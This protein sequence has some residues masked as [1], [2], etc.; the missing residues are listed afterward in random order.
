MIFPYLNKDALREIKQVIIIHGG[1]ELIILLPECPWRSYK[2]IWRTG[3]RPSD[4]R[5]HPPSLEE[6]GQPDREIAMKIGD[7]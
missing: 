6:W 7:R 5:D 4:H 1:D 2:H 3:R